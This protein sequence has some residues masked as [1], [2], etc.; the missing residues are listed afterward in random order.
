[1]IQFAAL[2]RPAPKPIA[3]PLAAAPRSQSTLALGSVRIT[4][5]TRAD[6]RGRQLFDVVERD[7]DGA[8]TR[9]QAR[10]VVAEHTAMARR[11][12]LVVEVVDRFG[13]V[14]GRA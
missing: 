10:D 4:T 2:A 6:S 5:R 3:L 8:E 11:A 14:G 12:G 13:D 9:R 7:L 1:M